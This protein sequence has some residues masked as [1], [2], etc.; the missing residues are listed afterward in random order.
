MNI[1]A[2][3][4]HFDDIEL[5]CGA[6]LKK[7]ADQGHKLYCYVGTT[8]GFASASTYENVRSG[9]KAEQEG[10]RAAELLGAQLECGDF[11]TFNLDYAHKL[12]TV[13]RQ[14]VE[15]NRIDWVFTHRN[16]DPHHD[17]WG[18]NMAVFH[19]A[20]QVKKVLAYQSSWY[21]ADRC[22]SPNFYVD[23]SDYWEFKM[24]LLRCFSS[25]YTRVGEKWRQFC[26][27]TSS[28]YG[29]KNDCRYAEGFECIRW[30][31]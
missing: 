21:D 30:L 25:E 7:L 8:S 23:I 5:G 15:K 17:H 3:G 12:N 11:S 27:T 26:E 19:G 14:L 13:I 10:R 4:A 24:Q 20:K 16:R 1:L 6:T 2:V 28:L 18:L 9:N 31:L 29:L 22:F